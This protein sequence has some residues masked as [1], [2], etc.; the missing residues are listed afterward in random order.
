MELNN[1]KAYPLICLEILEDLSEKLPEYL[2][3]HC[4]DH[5]IDV[6]N[7]CDLYINYYK[8]GKPEADLLRIAAVS[9]D[10]GYLYAPKNHEERGIIGIAPRLEKDY[11]KKEID[12]ISGLIRATRIPQNPQSFYEE[13]MADADLDYLG[14]EDYD[15][16]SERLYQE[17]LHYGVVHNNVEWLEVQIKFLENHHYHTDLAKE[18]RADTKNQKLQEL[19]T[20]KK[21]SDSSV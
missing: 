18:K 6:A 10:Y 5:M 12:F 3:Y 15:K 7:V 2:T 13:I 9:H 14:R 16:W 11:S 8:I 4:L 1:K 17:F 20:L 21:L 19:V